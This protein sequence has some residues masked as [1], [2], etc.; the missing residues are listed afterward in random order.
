MNR[1]MKLIFM[2]LRYAKE[3][4]DGSLLRAP[5]FEGFSEVQIHYHIGLCSE[6]GFL[7]VKRQSMGLDQA[8]AYGIFNLTWNGHEF[9]TQNR[10]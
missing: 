6:A 9:L 1:E 10:D 3:K 7:H 8:S 4:A 2:I 5:S